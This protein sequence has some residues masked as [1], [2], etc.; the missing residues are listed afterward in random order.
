VGLVPEPIFD[1]MK[2]PGGKYEKTADPVFTWLRGDAKR[3]GAVTIA[4]S[5]QDASIAYRI[6]G[7]PKSKTGWDLYVEPVRMKPGDVLRAMACRLGFRDSGVVTFKLGDELS[8][9]SA[10]THTDHWKDPLDAS[11]LHMRLLKLTEADYLGSNA[12]HALLSRVEDANPAIRYR[13]LVALHGSCKYGVDIGLAKT[14]VRGRLR[15]P[16]VVV[17]IAAAHA[18]CDWGNEDDGLPVLVA[19]LKHPTDK[20]R[21]FAMIALDKIG[22]KARPALAQIQAATRDKDNYVARVA[23]TAVARLTAR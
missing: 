19:A 15:D 5:T 10:T 17:R 9:R 3:G 8:D 7:D 20:A 23:K 6:G 21:L 4:C 13:T 14:A 2:R 16:S 11:N 18:L 22:N 12:P 1:E